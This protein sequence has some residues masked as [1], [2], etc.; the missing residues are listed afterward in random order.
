MEPPLTYLE[1]HAVFVLPPIALL[2][3]LAIRREDAWFDRRSLSGLAILLVLAVIYT[4]PWDNLLIAE[5]VWWYGEGTTLVTFWHA[6]LGEYLFFVLQP[7]LTCLWLFQFLDVRELSLRIPTSHRLL[8]AAGG[9]AVSAVGLALLFWTTS[10]YYLGAIL[11]WA[12]PILA[13]QWSFGITYVWHA[14]RLVALG[15]AVPT[16]YLWIADWIAIDMGI[17]VISPI[18]TTG[19]TLL[20]LPIE[21]ALFFLVT[22]VFAVQTLVLYVWLLDRQ[23]ELPAL[24]RATTWLA[25]RADVG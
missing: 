20:G 17:W 18:H 6:P 7:I 9:L 3:W 10:T 12:G 22:N 5:G 13:I 2:T 14:R 4:T 24:E 21:E 23:H 25:G 19:Y 8:G 16:V 15:V 11:F 1:F